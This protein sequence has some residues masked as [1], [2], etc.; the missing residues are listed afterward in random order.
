MPIPNQDL[1]KVCRKCKEE[2]PIENFRT[3][4]KRNRIYGICRSCELKE[5]EEYRKKNPGVALA[6]YYEKI[7]K[8]TPKELRAFRIKHREQAHTYYKIYRDKVFNHYGWKC[9][10]CGEE[11][12]EFLTIDHM[13]NDAAEYRKKGLHLGGEA[14]YRWLIANNFPKDFQ[15]L[16]MNCQWGK[17]RNNGICP[18]QVR[19]ND[20][21]EGE[22]LQAQGSAPAL[23]ESVI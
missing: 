8:M 7:E 13:K 18:H 14:V 20:Y 3:Y 23:N 10:C 4:K 19:R 12:R 17:R 5:A 11:I 16:C 2:K 22:Y 21:P 6:W 15:T 9:A 1:I